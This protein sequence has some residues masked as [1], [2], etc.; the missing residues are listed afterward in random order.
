[1]KAKKNEVQ[2]PYFSTTLEFLSVLSAISLLF[3]MGVMGISGFVSDYPIIPMKRALIDTIFFV[4][5]LLICTG[6]LNIMKSERNKLSYVKRQLFLVDDAVKKWHK[7][8]VLTI[9][10]VVFLTLNLL[11]ISSILSVTNTKTVEGDVTKI[12]KNV[13]VDTNES[14]SAVEIE[15]ED[16][17]SLTLMFGE[18][19]N[20]AIKPHAHVEGVY[21]PL[22]SSKIDGRLYEVTSIQK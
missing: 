19:V 2:K 21:K 1:M 6:T 12:V 5:V 4:I 10:I 3:S 18:S 8:F 17:T 9:M 15:K 20:G 16:G 7:A 22:E 13:S 14:L 11:Q